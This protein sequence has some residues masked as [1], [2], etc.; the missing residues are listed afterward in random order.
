MLHNA[1]GYGLFTGGL[2]APLRRR[3]ARD[4]G[5][6]RLGRHDRAAAAAD[7]GFP[8]RRARV[9]AQ[10]C[11]TLAQE[12]ASAAGPDEISLRS[13]LVGA[14]PWTEQL[15]EEIDRGLGVRAC[16][17]YGLSELIGPGVSCECI[18]ERNG[19]HITRI[20]SCPR[21][22]IPRA[23]SRCPRARW[24]CSSSRAHQAGAAARPLLDGRSREPVLRAVQLRPDPRPHERIRGRT[25]DMLIIRGVNVFPTQV[26]DVLGRC[27]SCLPTTSWS[28]AGSARWT[29]SRCAPR[30]TRRLLPVRRDRGALDERSKPITRSARCG[31]RLR[32]HQG[33]HRLLDEGQ[34]RRARQ[35]AALRGREALTRA[36]HPAAGLVRGRRGDASR[37]GLGRAPA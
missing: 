2:G 12:F 10:L 5:G 17:I 6:A 28:S 3:A 30:L 22:S 1:F 24:A 20:T 13:R 11:A 25:D 26:E 19:S 21:S 16:N 18:E 9:H 32:P 15:R 31:T 36:R 35:R 34:H 14:E 23:A 7:H 29:S 8:P 33:H 27:V 37:R 4:D